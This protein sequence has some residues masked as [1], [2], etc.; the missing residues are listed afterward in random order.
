MLSSVFL[1]VNDIFD[2]VVTVSFGEIRFKLYNVLSS[3]FEGTGNKSYV[4]YFLLLPGLMYWLGC[5]LIFF[6]HP[7]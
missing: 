7:I 2:S 6:F 4:T 5:S 1:L 3:V